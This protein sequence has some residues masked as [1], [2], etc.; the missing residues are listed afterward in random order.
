MSMSLLDAVNLCLRG[1]TLDEVASLDEVDTDAQN[2]QSTVEHNASVLQLKSWYFNTE[3]NW[4]LQ[5]DL[6]GH[7]TVPTGATSIVT[8]GSQRYVRNLTIRG[9]KI[10]DMQNHTYDLTDL[11]TGDGYLVVTL[12]MELDWDLLPAQARN[13]AAYWARLQFSQDSEVD[14]EKAKTQSPEVKRA[15][16]FLEAENRK[17]FKTNLY[18]DNPDIATKLSLIGGVNSR[19]YQVSSFPRRETY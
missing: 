8:S 7:I 11:L 1:A 19:G 4:K 18:Y 10:Y 9:S 16:D 14:L 6:N 13:A 17:Y 2:A 15:M 12:V 5:P 3:P